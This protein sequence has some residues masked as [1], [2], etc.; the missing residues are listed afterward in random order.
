[1][2]AVKHKYGWKRDRM[3]ENY[4][5]LKI[6]QKPVHKTYAPL[7]VLSPM[8]PVYDQGQLGSCTANSLAGA[9]QFD[10]MKEKLP[11][12][13]PSRLFIY[14]GERSLEHTISVDSGA[15]LSDGI[16]VLNTLGV[17]PETVW[18]YNINEFA[19]VPPTIAYSDAIK[20]KALLD[21]RVNVDPMDFKTMINLGYPV[22][23]GFTVY[24][25]FETIGANGIMPMPQPG[26][27]I[28]G[29]HAVLACG[30]NDTL[31]A[32]GQ[33]G[34]IKVRNSWSSSWGQGGYFWMPYAFLTP[35]NCNDCW[36]ITKNEEL[37]NELEAHLNS[38]KEIKKGMAKVIES[39]SKFFL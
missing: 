39:I 5:Y 14:Y 7:L 22:A 25:S 28:L 3:S 26:E 2:S 6:E 37:E 19:V 35:A 33:T 4:K 17:C 29:G 10:L 9:F 8:P 32:N 38:V 13:V 30:Y 24:Q 18:P 21:R 16:T 11:N 1:M 15:A 34:F 12:W 20:C 36:V 31:T 23:F 27:Q